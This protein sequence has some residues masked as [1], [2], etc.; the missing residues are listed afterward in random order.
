MSYNTEKKPNILFVLTDDQGYW[1]L[2]CN[3][4]NEIITPNI[5]SLASEGVRFENFFCVSPVC[6]PARASLLTGR[7]PSQHGVHDWIREGNT[8]ANA[9]E[10]LKDMPGYTEYLAQLG[11]NCAHSGKWHLGDNAKPQK[12][13]TRWYAHQ[14]GGGDY[15]N[16]PMVKNGELINEP[17]YV[18]DAITE[19]ALL[20]LDELTKEDKPFYLGVH[21]TA[22]HSPWTNGNHPIEL[23][24]LYDDCPFETCKVREPHP[25]AIYSTAPDAPTPETAKN[26]R[27]NLKGY[28]AAVTG[29]DRSVGRIIERL[30]ELQIYDNTLV[31]FTADN[32][33]NCG[34]HGIWGKG[35]GTFPLNMYDTSIKVPFIMRHPEVIKPGRVCKTM[36]SGYDFMPTILEYVGIENPECDELPGKSFYNQ[37]ILDKE[38]PNSRPVVVF[39]EYGP[40]RMIRTSEY[41][42]IYR[43][44][45]GPD[46]FYNLIKD[47][48]EEINCI[49]KLEYADTIKQLKIQMDEWFKK[50]VNPDMD[51]TKERVSGNGQIKKAGKYAEGEKNYCELGYRITY[52]I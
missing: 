9:I 38:S 20:F 43:Y 25:W 19:N 48:E 23:T 6:S 39:D 50:Y 30:K 37:L 2:G 36:V 21:Y 49:N 52:D 26:P 12:G 7:I 3:G 4:N 32:G 45:Y 1:A 18:T 35:N 24:S 14:R 11:Y 16:A 42:Y 41:K 44:P 51:G 33:F 17:T 15:Y 10:Y 5:D 13:F 34:H 27:E 47:P 29:V 28:F 31:I 40:V 22:P 8:G 46:E